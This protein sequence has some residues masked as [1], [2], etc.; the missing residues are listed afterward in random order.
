[1]PSGLANALVFILKLRSPL[2]A[3]K[4][5][6]PRRQRLRR[7]IK[8]SAPIVHESLHLDV[9]ASATMNETNARPDSGIFYL[10]TNKSGGKSIVRRPARPL[11][12]IPLAEDFDAA[13][14]GATTLRGGTIPNGQ[15]KR[16]QLALR[17]TASVV[18]RRSFVSPESV[19]LPKAGRFDPIRAFRKSFRK[20]HLTSPSL[21]SEDQLVWKGEE[22][23]LD[24][25]H[26]RENRISSKAREIHAWMMGKSGS[27]IHRSATYPTRQT[28]EH[29]SQQLPRRR[30]TAA[31]NGTTMKSPLSTSTVDR[32]PGPRPGQGYEMVN[33]QIIENNQEKTV[34]L[35]TWREQGSDK[36]KQ[37]DAE[38]ISVYYISADEYALEQEQLREEVWRF[39]E[40][41]G[42][43]NI[44]VDPF[45][46]AETSRT[47]N[48]TVQHHQPSTHSRSFSHPTQPP[49]Q[50]LP[51]SALR[52]GTISPSTS[53]KEGS[54][55]PS[56]LPDV[57]RRSHHISTATSPNPKNGAH[58]VSL[59]RNRRRYKESTPLV[60]QDQP[61]SLF[62]PTQSGSTISSIKS[63]SA[64]AFE[65]VLE[66][67]EPSLLHIA[68][69]LRSLGIRRV[70]HLR[71]IER[72]T[73]ATRDREL[74]ENALRLGI[75]VMEWAILVD[76]LLTF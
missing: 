42:T 29:G 46:G 71:A 26:Q 20:T 1:M 4:Y 48:R 35:S 28:E 14:Q 18:D 43:A 36:V 39:E 21:Q 25:N 13:T 27:D 5:K 68:P 6:R 24:R 22:Q 73:P 59:P 52:D 47:T 72:L 16:P 69:L 74:K 44:N 2:S 32:S 9:S 60:S 19:D 23:R 64:T 70:E 17:T 41:D 31:P 45:K 38:R 12:S 63:D 30:Q 62:H 33:R 3:S 75:T 67:C 50:P 61:R 51:A 56:R 54:S 7:P 34:E 76:K 8:I 49:I 15:N 55:Q 57:I 53:E 37:E 11:S 58:S 66:S 40:T 10:I 65:S